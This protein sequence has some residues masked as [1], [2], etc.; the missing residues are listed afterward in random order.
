MIK[1]VKT[2]L[3]AFEIENPQVRGGFE[4]FLRASGQWWAHLPGVWLV[5]TECTP[6]EIM[7]MI[8]HFLAGPDRMLIVEVD[9][10]K[11]RPRGW[12][13]ADGWAW[14]SDPSTAPAIDGMQSGVKKAEPE[15]KEEI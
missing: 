6:Q 7:D 8:K 11:Q 3:V 4:N 2:L 5:I 1:A 13:P 14:I 12:L 10:T 9:L 15:E